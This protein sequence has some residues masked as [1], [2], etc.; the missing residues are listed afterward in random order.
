MKVLVAGDFVPSGRVAA[1]IAAGDYSCLESVRPVV[2]EADFSLVNLECPLAPAS[3][4][5]I[6]KSGPNLKC[7]TAHMLDA[8]C[9]A[10][11]KGVTLANNHFR[12]YGQEGVEATLTACGERGLLTVGGGMNIDEASKILYIHADGQTVAVV[13]AYEEEFSIATSSA[14]GSNPQDAI[15]VFYAIK[16]A[17]EQA[18]HCVVITHGGVELYQLPTPRMQRCYR[19]F[20]DAG[21]DVVLN[22]H[23]HCPSGYEVYKGH[24]IF[25]GLGNFCFD[26]PGVKPT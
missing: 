23:Q 19:F 16:E 17:R 10:G 5:P 4:L 14:G 1:Q 20:V 21:A 12:D 3:A 26:R 7:E 11:F 24:P 2:E 6:R 18:D 13:N 9:Y 25:Y 22:H 8:L 15:R